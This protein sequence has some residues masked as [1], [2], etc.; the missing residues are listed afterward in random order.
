MTNPVTE[1]KTTDRYTVVLPV[2][3]KEK[4]TTLAKQHKISQGEVLEVL[5]DKMEP[6]MLGH[7]F[8]AK[9]EAKVAHR[10]ENSTVRK[11]LLTK[12]KNLPP[13]ELAKLLAVVAA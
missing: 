2:Q 3:Y 6:D 9:R 10:A 12:I 5:L 1:E 8:D 7:H 4:I 11:Q 13:E